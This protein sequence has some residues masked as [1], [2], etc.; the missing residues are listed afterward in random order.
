MDIIPLEVQFLVI[1]S[2]RGHCINVCKI[3]EKLLKENQPNNDLITHIVNRDYYS[4]QFVSFN[5]PNKLKESNIIKKVVIM[6]DSLIFKIIL[7]RI[8]VT[9]LPE[10]EN[11]IMYFKIDYENSRNIDYIVNNIIIDGNY[12]ALQ[13]FIEI[14]NDSG[15][16]DDL[17]DMSNVTNIISKIKELDCHHFGHFIMIDYLMGLDDI[18]WCNNDLKFIIKILSESF[19]TFYD[20]L[21]N[22]YKRDHMKFIMLIDKLLNKQKIKEKKVERKINKFD[23]FCKS[24][25]SQHDILDDKKAYLECVRHGLHNIIENVAAIEINNLLIYE[26]EF[27]FFLLTLSGNCDL[28]NV[29][30]FYSKYYDIYLIQD[31][32][33][34]LNIKERYNEVLSII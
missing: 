4:I 29:S 26:N 6:N 7:N 9:L 19:D 10:S 34:K 24:D 32:V 15:F 27:V 28:E 5:F 3:W 18:D 20:H 8:Y 2:V 12:K 30:N 16:P 33:G 31:F 13:Y 22:I 11:I 21:K 25:F 14:H 23:F 1:N 17:T